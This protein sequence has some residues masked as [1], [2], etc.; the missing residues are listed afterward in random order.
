MQK[1]SNFIEFAWFNAVRRSS[2]RE[3]GIF[4]NKSAVERRRMLGKGRVAKTLT[5]FSFEF[6]PKVETQVNK[7]GLRESEPRTKVGCASADSASVPPMQRFTGDGK[8][9][10]KRIFGRCSKSWKQ[11]L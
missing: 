6:Q 9:N 2:F 11:D 7:R 1:N 4:G 3:L 8:P 5:G 10:A